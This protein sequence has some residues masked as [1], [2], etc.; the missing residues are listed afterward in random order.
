MEVK[1]TNHKSIGV[2]LCG[3]SGSRLYPATKVV[4]KHFFNVY[5]K[6]MFYYPLSTLIYSGL[7]NIL[8]VCNKQDRDKFEIFTKEIQNRWKIKITIIIQQKQ[9]KGILDRV[10]SCMEYLNES[11]KICLI[12]G[13][14]FFFGR[15]ITNI[16]KKSLKNKKSTIFTHEVN[17]PSGYGILYKDKRNQLLKIIEKPKNKKS[18]NA[19]TGLYIY[20]KKDL[21]FIDNIKPSKKNELEI[22]SLNKILLKNKSLSEISLGKGITWFDLGTYND[23]LSC[24]NFIQIIQ[25]KL[26]FIISDI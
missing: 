22:S 7:K 17:D 21:S 8:L 14:N 24:S 9:S 4:N 18:N 11:N 26:G 12:L 20:N 3:G 1:M 2:L 23:L 25:Q 6:P 5:D 10:V 16:V 13:D 19:I 15:D